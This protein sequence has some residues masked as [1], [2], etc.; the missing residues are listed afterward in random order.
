[1]ACGFGCGRYLFSFEMI[2]KVNRII[3]SWKILLERNWKEI[4]TKLKLN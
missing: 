3:M 4:E 1:M 2:N